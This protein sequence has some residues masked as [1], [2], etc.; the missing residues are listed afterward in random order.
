M[1][2]I[3]KALT[4]ASFAEDIRKSTLDDFTPRVTSNTDQFPLCVWLRAAGTAAQL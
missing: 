4:I 3:A 1:F 2:L